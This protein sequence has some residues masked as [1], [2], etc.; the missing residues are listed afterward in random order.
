MFSQLSC[1]NTVVFNMFFEIALS[2]KCCI[3]CSLLKFCSGT[4][5]GRVTSIKNA[6]VTTSSMSAFNAK[7]Q[8][9]LGNQEIG[10]ADISKISIV[11]RFGS[12]GI[13]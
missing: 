4:C 11:G 5:V 10:H 9:G 2:D 13:K 8:K 12:N 6:L 7:A 3:A 1:V